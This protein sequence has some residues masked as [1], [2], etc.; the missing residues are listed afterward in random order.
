MDLLGETLAILA[1]GP[2][3]GGSWFDGNGDL[4]VQ[5]RPLQLPRLVKQAF[6]QIRQAAADNPAVLIRLLSTLGRLAPKMQKSE[7]RM[8]L[9]EQATA[10]W[11]TANTRTLVKMDREDIEAAWQK[12]KDVLAAV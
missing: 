11:D 6:D 2:P 9:L 3:I 5:V 4:R 1:A 7:D 8:A 10:V 12:A